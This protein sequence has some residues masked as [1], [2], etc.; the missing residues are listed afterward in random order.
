MN[1]KIKGTYLRN[2]KSQRVERKT[3]L[4]GKILSFHLCIQIPLI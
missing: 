1:D 4:K 3:I 2:G